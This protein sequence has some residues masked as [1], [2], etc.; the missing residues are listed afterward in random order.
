MIKNI[1]DRQAKIIHALVGEY[2]IGGHPVGS[3]II[4]E[5]YKLDISSATVRK[6]MSVLEQMGYLLSPHT[7][8][9]RIPTDDAIQY[10]VNELVGLYQITMSQKS[11]LD[12]FYKKAKWQLDQLLKRTAQLLSITS[13]SAAIVLAPV[14][15]GSIIKRVE[16]ISIADNLILAV[17]ICQSGSIFQ[18]KIK[19][20]LAVSQEKLYK[21]SRC[22]NQH[23]KG[24]EI[25]D[26]QGKGLGFLA[27][28]NSLQEDEL[29]NI[30][31]K[32][33][34]SLVYNPPDQQVYIDGE[35]NFYRQLLENLSDVNSVEVIMERLFDH[36]LVRKII[37]RLRDT[38]KVTSRIGIELGDEY[39]PGI[40]ILTKG[41]SVGGRDMGALGVIGNKPNTL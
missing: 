18:K 34:Q 28:S 8:A 14:S 40:S 15:T 29:M 30:A 6:E 9:G 41:Y 25:A 13:Q 37:N 22:L 35:A 24:Y 20:E 7:S 33:V 36:A 23:L 16:L 3:H 31:I 19:T 12:A 17:V 32:V 4:V 27:Q 5:K 2:I 10:Y 26:L 38:S 11:K 1:T 39:I 21:I